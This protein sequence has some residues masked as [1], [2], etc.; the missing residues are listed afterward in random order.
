MSHVHTEVLELEVA[1]TP[2]RVWRAILDL[3]HLAPTLLP[4]LF[5]AFSYIKGSGEVGSLREVRIKSE[6]PTPPSMD[7]TYLHLLACQ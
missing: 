4:D 1:V 2:S 6:P 7:A 5:E 3:P